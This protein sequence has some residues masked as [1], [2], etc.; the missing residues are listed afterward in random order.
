M[1]VGGAPQTSGAAAPWWKFGHVWLIVA[2]T[3]A[4]LAGG[5]FTVYLAMQAPPEPAAATTGAQA[6]D[7]AALEPALQARNRTSMRNGQAMGRSRAPQN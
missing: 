2:I 7:N 4:A 5:L 1:A 6:A 3:L